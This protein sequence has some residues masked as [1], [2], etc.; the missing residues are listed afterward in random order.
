MEKVFTKE[1]TV[2]TT[3]RMKKRDDAIIVQAARLEGD[4]RSEFVRKAT[5]AAAKRIISKAKSQQE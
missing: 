5:V 4:S 2:Q 3:Y 1:Q